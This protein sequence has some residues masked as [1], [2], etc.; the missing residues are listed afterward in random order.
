[1]SV[2]SD[3]TRY[4]GPLET[5]WCKQKQIYSHRMKVHITFVL[6]QAYVEGHLTRFRQC[7]FTEVRRKDIRSCGCDHTAVP[8]G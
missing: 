1:M 5:G 7:C 3:D 6:D 2:C 8:D 4:F